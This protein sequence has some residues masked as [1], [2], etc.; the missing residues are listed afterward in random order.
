MLVF[1][2]H[3]FNFAYNDIRVLGNDNFILT[4]DSNL[5]IAKNGAVASEVVNCSQYGVEV[6][7]E[8]G[9]AIDAAITS[10]ICVGTINSFASGIGGGGFM[11]I[12]LPNGHSEVIDFRE[13]APLAA[14]KDMFV[15]KQIFASVG[16]LSIGVPGEVAGM[17]L[18]HKKLPWKRLFEP[19]INM[20]RKGFPV[21][22]E[23]G[24]RLQRHREI[25]VNNPQLSEIYAP[26]GNVLKEGQ[27]LYRTKFADTLETI[28]NNHT[29]FYRGSIAKSIIKRVKATGGIMTLED[30]ENYRPIVRKP[31]VGFY[32]GRKILTTPEPSSG[33]VL[34][35]LLNLLEKYDLKNNKISGLNLHRIVESLKFGFARQTE[36]GDAAF[37]ENKTEHELRLAEIISKEYADLVRR[38][39][40]DSGFGFVV[41]GGSFALTL[42]TTKN[43]TFEP[44]YYDPVFEPVNDYGTSHLSVIDADDMAVSI[45]SSINQFWGSQVVDPDTE[46][47]LNDQMDDFSVPGTPDKYGLLPS[48]YNFIAPGKRPLSS[49]IPTIIEKDERL[50]FVVG[51]SGSKKIISSVLEV[52]LESGFPFDLMEH[53][54]DIGH[55][56]SEDSFVQ[57]DETANENRRFLVQI[58]HIN[59]RGLS[60][61]VQAVRRFGNGT[62]H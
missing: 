4:T 31:L 50:E 13:T 38:N 20:C 2:Y 3:D 57:A 15:D 30:L 21:P 61:Q 28:A 60:S 39:I 17:K 27:I 47:L 55:V 19:S 48:P 54:L 32:H 33:S 44:E 40:S 1:Y 43:E 56:R 12:R 10:M 7:K 35:F 58:N 25:V 59:E 37:F 26:N 9:N 22:P 8:G 53:L 41:H 51:G 24:L 14:K 36:L 5:I 62:I 52:L 34:I 42:L 46:I 49:M 16:G 18:A 6:L 45:T 11:V 29:E 23:L